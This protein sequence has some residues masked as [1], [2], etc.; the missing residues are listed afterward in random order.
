MLGLLLVAFCWKVAGNLQNS[1]EKQDSKNK[2]K[3]RERQRDWTRFLS[4]MMVLLATLGGQGEG[5]GLKTGDNCSSGSN[6]CSL[7]L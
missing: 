6:C 4:P 2:Q 1:Q 7:L 5:E 3:L